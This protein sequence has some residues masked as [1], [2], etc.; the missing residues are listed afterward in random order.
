MESYLHGVMTRWLVGL[1]FMGLL[2]LYGAGYLSPRYNTYDLPIAEAHDTL[3]R[4]PLPPVVFGSDADAGIPQFTSVF[5]TTMK[6][7]MLPE[8]GEEDIMPHNFTV[9][10]ADP[11][12]IVW[13]LQ[14]EGTPVFS[15]IA[16]LTAS[17]QNATRVTVDMTGP[18][19][20][21]SGEAAQKLNQNPTIKNMYITAMKE[22]IAASLEGRDFNLSSVYPAMM[23]A[24]AA[25]FSQLS[26]NMNDAIEADQKRTEDNIE[27]AYEREASGE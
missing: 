16:N 1:G 13:T 22:Q 5:P 2:F 8:A 18:D 6:V 14:R 27:K 19:G 9:N 11:G 23:A 4:T 21:N 12:R 26:K 7:E 24:T 3:A 25:N 20:D 17:G 15:L 10:A